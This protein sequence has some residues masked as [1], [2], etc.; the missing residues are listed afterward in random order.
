M[1]GLAAIRRAAAEVIV[2]SGCGCC[3]GT[4]YDEHVAAL[5]KLLR[6]PKYSDGSG[7]NFGKFRRPTSSAT[8]TKE[9]S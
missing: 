1:K 2:S 4:N 8:P 7:Y 3:R 6:V 5:A 9:K